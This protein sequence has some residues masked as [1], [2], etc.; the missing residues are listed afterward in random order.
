MAY[1]GNGRTLLVLGSNVRD[2]ITPGYESASAP[3]PFDKS[4]FILSQ[5]VPGGYE[6]NV[7]V[8]EQKYITET[9][10]T[11]TDLID[12]LNIDSTTFKVF[13]ADASLASALSDIKETT[14]TYASQNHT[15]TISGDATVTDNNGT[16]NI[17]SLTYDGATAEI[18][19]TKT[20]AQ[21]DSASE[22]NISISHS[23]SGYWEVLE[24]EYDYTIG[25]TGATY[26]R[27]ITFSEAPQFNDK[28]YVIHKGD[29]TY[30]LVP[31]DNSVGPNQLSQNLRNFVVDRFTASAQTE[32][33]LSQ[34]SINSSALE[35]YVDGVWKEGRNAGETNADS[36]W[37]LSSDGLTVD[38]DSAVTGRVVIKHLGFSTISRRESLSPGQT[39]SIPDGS[40]TQAKLANS[41]VV[42]T[43]VAS[44][45]VTNTKI[46]NDAVT[47]PKIRL[48]NNTALRINKADTTAYSAVSI[49]SSDELILDAPTTAH[50]SVNGVKKLNVSS[51][52]ISAET[53][54]TIALG[55]S[56]KKFTDAHFSGQ[57]NSATADITGNI[58]VGGT[59]DGVDVSALSATVTSLQNLVE[60]LVPIGTMSIWT[61]STSPNSKWLVCD[62]SAVSRLTYLELFACIGTSFGSGDGVNTFNLPDMRRRLPIGKSSS[63]TI[64][65][66]DGLVEASRLL[67]HTHSVPAH[68]HDLS[69]HTHSLPAHYHGMGTGADL[70]IG[71]ANGT[72]A[73]KGGHTT[74]IDIS[75]GHTASSSGV[76]LTTNGSSANVS[77]SDPGHNHGSGYTGYSD[78]LHSHSGTTNSAGVHDHD[79]REESGGG[80][81]SANTININQSTVGTA[82]KTGRNIDDAGAHT[83]SFTTNSTSINHRHTI[84]SST[85]GVS[86]S[87]T[88]HTHTINSHS[89]T[90]TVASLGT[91]NR[92]DTSGIHSH[93][94]SN[95]AGRIGLVTGGVDGNATMTSGTPSVNVTGNSSVLTSG[96][97]N[98]V[99][100]TIVNYIIRAS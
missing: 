77:L 53:T 49:N 97:S 48:S 37:A 60:N 35:V 2:D 42:E 76:S 34:E 32:F 20:G 64:G 41:S 62:G 23:Y 21:N 81:N 9:L 72:N 87:Q 100:Y 70:N 45:A 90:I 33:I 1:I 73:D 75:H 57:V 8:F 65:N 59:V 47:S 14:S 54:E 5:E 74:T 3:D 51:T 84:S 19:L 7:Y 56:S 55:S 36:V 30:N 95:F 61:K 24:P 10:V 58:T 6:N 50:V 89:H 26:N 83:H 69:N 38:F 40:I 31:S 79:L 39:G 46:G 91:T 18:V 85:T 93:A 27:E 44:S 28:I 98:T 94:S 86:L 92:T 17:V 66:T 15:L 52:E 82:N 13:T 68:T 25:G 22:T 29:A 88:A 63:D 78:P 4:T 99:P 43:K 12:I 11:S 16:F 96:A 71:Q 67:T 80:L